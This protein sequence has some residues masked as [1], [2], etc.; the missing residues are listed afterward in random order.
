MEGVE[1]DSGINE[2][3]RKM[4]PVAAR[5][6]KAKGKGWPYF[7]KCSICTLLAVFSLCGN[8]ICISSIVFRSSLKGSVAVMLCLLHCYNRDRNL[9]RIVNKSVYVGV[10]VG[11]R[12]R[13]CVLG[14][15]S[16]LLV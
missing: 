1:R 9:S 2:A 6:V 4:Q 13:V 10:S 8:V 5:R 11:M 14:Y 12:A 16:L 3:A 15:Y 7:P